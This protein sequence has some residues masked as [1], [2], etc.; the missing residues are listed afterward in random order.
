MEARVGGSKKPRWEGVMI[1][2][3]Y[4]CPRPPY[5]C[6]ERATVIVVVRWNGKG[7]RNVLV[8]EIQT[9]RRWVRPFRGMRR[10]RHGT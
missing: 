8:E 9:G 1:G 10:V 3:Q 2:N 5:G 4:I 7:P 6:K